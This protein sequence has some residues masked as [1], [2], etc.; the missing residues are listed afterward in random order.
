MAWFGAPRLEEMFE[1]LNAGGGGSPAK[2]LPV[3][4][5]GR[6][7]LAEGWCPRTP[8]TFGPCGDPTVM[9]L[10]WKEKREGGGYDNCNPVTMRG[11]GGEANK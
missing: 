6:R 8:D 7:L 1:M 5:P 2:L 11:V 4:F 9:S 3:L 10:R